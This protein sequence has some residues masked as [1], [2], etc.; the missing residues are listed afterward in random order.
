MVDVP[1]SDREIEL[2]QYVIDR[3]R[4]AML[5]EIANTDSRDLRAYLQDREDQFIALVEKLESF[6]GRP[7]FSG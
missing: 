2:I 5:F 4:K 3:Y 7:E 1:L 6:T